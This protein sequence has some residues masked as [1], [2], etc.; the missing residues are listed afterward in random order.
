MKKIITLLLTTVMCFSVT[1]C[2]GNQK[3]SSAVSESADSTSTVSES[4]IPESDQAAES[5]EQVESPEQATSADTEEQGI[6]EPESETRILV[7]YFSNTGNTRAIAKSIAAGVNADIYE[8]VAEV[9]YTEA[10]LDYGDNNSRSTLEM[11]DPSVRPAISGIVENMDQYEKIYI[12]IQSG[13]VR[14]HEL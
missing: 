11:N 3:S 4:V 8:I 1:A 10:D 12:G 5:S 9:P 6:A 14:H 13:G 2:G 7:A